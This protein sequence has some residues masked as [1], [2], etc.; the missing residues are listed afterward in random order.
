MIE[1]VTARKQAEQRQRDAQEQLKK[2]LQERTAELSQVLRSLRSQAAKRK[3]A[4]QVLRAVQEF[5]DRSIAPIGDKSSA[6]KGKPIPRKKAS[7]K[8]TRKSASRRSSDKPR[9]PSP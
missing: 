8:K 4:D 3:P 9:P 2:Q 5:I 1:D 6:G 7:F